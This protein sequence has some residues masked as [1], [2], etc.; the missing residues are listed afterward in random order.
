MLF[1]NTIFKIEETFEY[2]T[3]YR[4]PIRTML[5]INKESRLTIK[6]SSNCVGFVVRSP[7]IDNPK[8]KWACFR[9]L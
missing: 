2:D 6:E 8:L 3:C 9:R 4:Y 1:L 7:T 5:F